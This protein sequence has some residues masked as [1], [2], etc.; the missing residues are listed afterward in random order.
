[1]SNTMK[2]GDVIIISLYDEIF[3]TLRRYGHDLATSEQE[4]EVEANMQ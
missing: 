3:T 2:N 4:K 1:M